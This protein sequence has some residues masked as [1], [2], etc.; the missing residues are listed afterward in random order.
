MPAYLEIQIE[1]LPGNQEFIDH[2]DGMEAR[3]AD[4]TGAY[5]ALWSVF[6]QRERYRFRREGPGWQELE[7]PTVLERERLDI[8]GEHPILNR[9]GADDY[10]GRIGGTLR[11]S[12]CRMDGHYAVF[13]PMGDG[14]RMGTDDPVAVYHQDGTEHMTSRPV[15]DM[16]EADAE[17]FA[18][19]FDEWI[20]L[21]PGHSMT[22]VSDY[23]DL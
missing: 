1:P 7:D 16:T 21:L 19:V 23:E 20:S 10:H 6:R 22:I 18:E 9:T 5:A 15:I 11:N 8:D 2:L 3:T 17:A 14:I 4:T 12:L 13:E